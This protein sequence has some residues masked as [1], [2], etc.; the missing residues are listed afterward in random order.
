MCACVYE[1]QYF[2]KGM[3]IDMKKRLIVT[4]A[5][6]A[7]ALTGCGSGP[8][9]DDVSRSMEA[10]YMAGALLKYDK[11]NDDMLDYDRSVLRATPTPEP[12]RTPV[13]SGSPAASAAS[14]NSSDPGAASDTPAV[15]YV[16]AEQV[17]AMNQVD[18]KQMS[19]EI[20]ST[21]GSADAA[22]SAHKGKEL[23]IVHFRIKNKSSVSQKV[24]LMKKELQYT[25]TADGEMVGSP[26]MTILSND[27]LYFKEKMAPGRSSE[28]VLVFETDKKQT[29]QNMSIQVTNGKMT[30]EI[31]IH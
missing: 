16:A 15:N 2:E 20:K 31:T 24:N 6:M 17:Y 30:G 3:I 21:Y 25:L 13:P 22:I 18:I 11:N 10:E 5:V 14:Q 7:L 23:L 27:L 1:K 19:S 9:L 29:L 8:N 4:A 26:L 28:A 12:T